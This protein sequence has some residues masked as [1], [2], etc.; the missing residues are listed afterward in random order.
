MSIEVGYAC[1]S[2][3]VYDSG[4]ERRAASATSLLLVVFVFDIEV[5]GVSVKSLV[6]IQ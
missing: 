2:C 5:L 1:V 4:E 3:L 6:M